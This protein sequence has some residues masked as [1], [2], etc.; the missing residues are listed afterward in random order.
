MPNFYTSI[1]VPSLSIHDNSDGELNKTRTQLGLWMNSINA[2]RQVYRKATSVLVY[3][4]DPGGYVYLSCSSGSFQ[5]D[6]IMPTVN[7]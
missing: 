5:K 1:Q 2:T 4:H 3:Q 6:R 7:V